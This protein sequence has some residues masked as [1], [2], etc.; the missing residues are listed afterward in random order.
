MQERKG[1][2]AG[3]QSL[4]KQVEMRSRAQVEGPAHHGSG[5]PHVAGKELELEFCTLFCY[6]TCSIEPMHHIRLLDGIMSEQR[7]RCVSSHTVFP[8]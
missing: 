3:V 6:R 5:E 1:E 8:K 4:R 7:G 2:I